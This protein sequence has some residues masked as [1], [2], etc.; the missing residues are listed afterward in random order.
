[1]TVLTPTLGFRHGFR[2]SSF[3]PDQGCHLPAQQF[4][5]LNCCKKSKF[6]SHCVGWSM[7]PA[8]KG[9]KERSMP[10]PRTFSESA[11]FYLVR[12]CQ[13]LELHMTLPVTC[14]CW[15]DI[16]IARSSRGQ[17]LREKR[18]KEEKSEDQWRQAFFNCSRSRGTGETTEDEMVEWHHRLDGR[19][20]DPLP[21]V[22]DGQG[23]LA[24]CSPWGHQ[25][26][27]MTERLNWTEG[28]NMD[29]FFNPKKQ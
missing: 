22:G 10:S 24:C 26:S 15:A 11:P 17:W 13:T 16:S 1:M 23:G 21:G 14:M 18:E 4:T 2:N 8:I 27:D 9:R 28:Q 20:F 29:F 3:P 12:R 25:E 19:E 6:T 7:W 5:W